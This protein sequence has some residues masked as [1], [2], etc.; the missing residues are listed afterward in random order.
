MEIVRS[1]FIIFYIFLQ[2]YLLGGCIRYAIERK[3]RA[4]IFFGLFYLTI[5][6]LIALLYI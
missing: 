4:A 3:D 5:P 2:I 6:N 1:M